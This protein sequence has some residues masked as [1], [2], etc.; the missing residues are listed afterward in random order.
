[1][2]VTHFAWIAH[3]LESSNETDQVGLCCF[4]QTLL[5]PLPWILR[6]FLKLLTISCMILWNGALLISRSV[7]FWYR[8]ISLNATVPGLNLLFFC[9]CG[10]LC[11][12][13]TAIFLEAWTVLTAAPSNAFLTVCFVLA[14][15]GVD[16]DRTFCKM[17]AISVLSLRHLWFSVKLVL[18]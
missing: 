14:I 13:F 1:M 3:R 17:T 8:R 15:L 11:G 5:L 7:D 18:N 2:M 9:I 16:L 4:L 12:A 6:S 10:G